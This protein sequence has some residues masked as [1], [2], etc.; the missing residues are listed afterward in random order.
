VVWV[1]PIKLVAE[2]NYARAV[3]RNRGRRGTGVSVR[4]IASVPFESAKRGQSTFYLRGVELLAPVRA[5]PSAWTHACCTL[6]NTGEMALV[7]EAAIERNVG[8]HEVLVR[9]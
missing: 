7:G 1:R 9:Q 8:Y 2:P 6:E 5:A 4:L 3:A